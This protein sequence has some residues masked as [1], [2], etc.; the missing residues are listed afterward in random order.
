MRRLEEADAYPVQVVTPLR[1]A[2]GFAQWINSM[3]Y[4]ACKVPT[5]WGDA[6]KPF[7]SGVGL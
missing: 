3:E 7:V 4:G 1:I 2:R 6:F 5:V